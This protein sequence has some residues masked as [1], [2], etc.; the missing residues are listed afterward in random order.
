V[1]A[2]AL[3]RGL[4]DSFSVRIQDPIAVSGWTGRD[5]PEVDI[6]VVAARRYIFT[7]AAPDA[8]AFVEVADSTYGGRRGDRRYRIPLYVRAGVPSWIVNLRTRRVECYAS[9]SDLARPH[10]REF[11]EGE[12]FDVLGVSISVSDLF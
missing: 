4:P 9:S 12:T 8:S 10:G 3:N 11:G 5:A 6:A 2:K 1:L 7:P